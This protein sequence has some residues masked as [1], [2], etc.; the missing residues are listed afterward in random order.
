MDG[1]RTVPLEQ[2][3]IWSEGGTPSRLFWI[4]GLAGSGKS[5]IAAT[6][7][8]RLRAE[9]T[10]AGAFFCKR[11]VPEQRD[12]RRIL[13]SLSFL[14]AK[15][16]KPYRDLVCVALEKEADI[17]ASP[18]TYQLSTL[19]TIPFSALQEEADCR[20][21]VVDALDECG[22]SSTRLQIADCLCQLASLTTW[23]KV[24]VSSRPQPEISRKFSASQ[25]VTTLDLNSVDAESDIMKYTKSC[26]ENLVN[27]QNLDKKWMD[28]EVA[29]VLAKKA[30]GLFIWMSTVTRF[31]SGQ[32]DQ[33]DA[34]EKITS[35]QDT[36]AGSSL[37]SLYM[38]VLQSSRRGSDGANASLL[39]TVLGIIYITAKNRPLSI[40]GLHQFMPSVGGKGR[41]SKNTLK[42]IVD[43]LRSVLYEDGSQGGIIRVC[44]PSFLDFL[45]N[46]ERCGDYWTNADQLNQMMIEKCLN[47]MRTELKFNI[48]ALESSYR[49]NGDVPDLRRRIEEKVS[50]SLQYSC[51]YWTTHLNDVNRTVVDQLVSEFFGSLQV[52]FWLE[53]LGLIGDL[54]KGLDTLQ[55]IGDIYQV[56]R[57]SL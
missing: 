47:V 49:A 36:Y 35:G 40:D 53:V 57:V 56:R 41:L 5:T 26:L 27:S 1:T 11:D 28:D 19:F 43:D 44:H 46:H 21:F 51:L 25:S 13:P 54:K 7:C 22:D 6:V 8:E 52:L 4:N 31:I 18:L 50:E 42:A 34:M 45:E 33:D 30:S 24:F 38:T 39:K 17:L 16:H 20:I 9:G 15:T 2:I 14:L 3:V 29:M 55:A 48:C 32:Y 10:L 12:P 23:L 37:D